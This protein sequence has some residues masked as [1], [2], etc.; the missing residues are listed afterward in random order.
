MTDTAPQIIIAPEF[1]T[2]RVETMDLP[3]LGQTMAQIIS[4]A[5]AQGKLDPKDLRKVQVYVDGVPLPAETGDQRRAAMRYVPEPGSIVNVVVNAQGG[6]GG[7]GDKAL[8]TVLQIALVVASFYVGGPAGPLAAS[9]AWV[10]AAAAVAVNVGGQMALSAIFAPDGDKLA[11]GQDKGALQ[12]A[13]NRYRPRAPMP[14]CLGL[15]RWGFDLA[16]PPYTTLIGQDQ[17]LNLAVAPHYGRCWVGNLKIGETLLADYPAADYSIEYFLEP[18]VPRR[19]YLYPNRVVQQNTQDELELGSAAEVYTSADNAERIELDVAFPN[20]LRWQKSSGKIV[21]QEVQGVIEYQAVGGGA[22]TPAPIGTF[23][24]KNGAAVPAGNWY[25]AGKT[26]DPIRRTFGFAV[27]KGQYNVRIRAFNPDGGEP[28][29]EVSD[30]TYLTAVRSIERQLP[31]IDENLAVIFLRIKSTDDLN[32]NLP[33][34]TGECEPIIPVYQGGNWNTEARSSNAAAL[35][36]W[37]LTGPAAA[38]PMPLGEFHSSLETT[39]DLIEANPSWKGALLVTEEKSQQ[40]VMVGLG[41]MGR[42]STFWNGSK[43]CFVPDWVRDAPRQV[44]TGRN[45]GGYRY[46]RTFPEPIHAVF[47]EFLNITEGSVDD[48]LYVYADG[49]DATNATLIESIRLDFA[50]EAERA[51]QEGRVYIAKRLLQVEMHE[52]QAGIDAV[53]TTYGDRVLVRHPATLYG[54]ADGR[55]MFRRWAGALVAGFRLDE[56]VEMEAGKTYGIDIRRPDGVIRGIPVVNVAGRTRDLAFAAPREAA[57][58]PRKGDMI[59]FGETDIITEDVEIIDVSPETDFSVTFRAIPYIG[60]QIADAINNPIPTIISRVTERVPPP[61]PRLTPPDFAIPSGLAIEATVSTWN[62]TPIAGFSG[63]WRARVVDAIE[64]ESFT[65]WQ[66]LR[67]VSGTNGILRTG[68]I[69]GAANPPDGGQEVSIDIEARTLLINGET[70]L[71]TVIEGIPVLAD[72]LAP[73]TFA[74][75]GVTR[76]SANGSSFGAIAVSATAQAAGDVQS[77]EVEAS[78][79]G[80]GAWVTP[81][82]GMLSARNPVGDLLGLKEGA[83]GYD[84]RARWL[85]AD[86]WPGPWQVVAGVVI[87]EGSSVSSDTKK[88]GGVNADEIAFN[89]VQVP[90]LVTTLADAQAAIATHQAALYTATT[91]VIDR[92][93][94]ARNTLYTASTG[95]VDR[96]NAILAQLNTP[97]TGVVAVL[98]SHASAI[99]DLQTGKAD[100]SVVTVLQSQ[101]NQAGTGIL[102][103]LATEEATSADLIANKANA[104]RV[105]LIEASVARLGADRVTEPTG[106]NWT[107]SAADN[108]APAVGASYVS[109]DPL[110]YFVTLLSSA[111]IAPQTLTKVE[112]GKLYRSTVQFEQVGAVDAARWSYWYFD[113]AGAYISASGLT[114]TQENYAVGS[115]EVLS[116]TFGLAGSG[117]TFILPATAI[118]VRPGFQMMRGSVVGASVRVRRLSAFVDVTAV[119]SAASKIA[120][121]E[122]TTANLQTGK[123]DASRVTLLEAQVQQAGTGLL[124]RTTAVETATSNLQ[125]GKADASRVTLLEAQVQQAGTGLLARMTA[126]ETATVNLQT[127]KADAS[128]VTSLEAKVDVRPNLIPNGSGR[129]GLLGWPSYWWTTNDWTWGRFFAFTR[130]ASGVVPNTYGMSE[131]LRVVP[132]YPYVLS[133]RGYVNGLT[134]GAVNLIVFAYDDNQGNGQVNLGQRALAPRLDPNDLTPLV[135]NI[136]AGKNFVRVSPAMINTFNTGPMDLAFWNL[137]LEQGTAP[138]VYS[139]EATA[140]T[141]GARTSTLEVATTNLQTGKA[142]ASRVTVVE[143][144]FGHIASNGRIV[145]AVGSNFTRASSGSEP[146]G[147]SFISLDGRGYF[148]TFLS[149]QVLLPRQLTEVRAGRVYKARAAGEQLTA[150]DTY[151]WIGYAFD[152]AGALIGAY[153]GA[154]PAMPVGAFTVEDTFGLAGSGAT[155]ILPAGT[156]AFRAG[157]QAMRSSG[158]GSIRIR[159]LTVVD[160]SDAATLGASVTSLQTA[161]ATMEGRLEGRALLQV[162]GGNQV[163]GMQLLA[164][165]GSDVSYSTIDFWA[166]AVRISNDGTNA[167]APFEVRGDVVRMKAALIDRLS[168]GTAISVG[169]FGFPVAL[170]AKLQPAK[171]GEVVSYGGDLG[172]VPNILWPTTGLDPLNAGESYLQYAE[173]HTSTGFIARR[174][175]QTPATPSAYNLTTTAAGP[176]TDTSGSTGPARIIT[177]G[178]NPVSVDNTYIITGQGVIA[179]KVNAFPTIGEPQEGTLIL[180]VWQRISGVWSSIGFLYCYASTDE[181][182][183]KFGTT[184][185]ETAGPASDSFTCSTTVEAWGLSLYSRSGGTS[186]YRSNTMSVQYTAQGTGAGI[187]TATAGNQRPNIEIRLKN[188]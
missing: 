107:L 19:S 77:L 141:L 99:G 39:Y 100:V 121:L 60:P 76:V 94:E 2:P 92:L 15:R 167:V 150:A 181:E 83:P 176:G 79:A 101:I 43:L 16:A 175:I 52:W 97:T 62:G 35:T 87:P 1:M 162:Q 147:S 46:R 104:S 5:I 128:R 120:T 64:G 6:G 89:A 133:G 113:A 78:P 163:S 33:V 164:V 91:G 155:I 69:A 72:L 109:S 4:A 37:L 95:L 56:E 143:A 139:E 18:G 13:A 66:A 75:E 51:F 61:R 50:C 173:G 115:H 80:A 26:K 112:A 105:A 73:T 36:R 41:K 180:R 93:T 168:V 165:S 172:Q 145:D 111:T 67:P 28:P 17:Y 136:P 158:A 116:P 38:K 29:D 12:D 85:Q 20:G 169:P 179:F 178:A 47:V 45:A 8:Q 31:I 157:L 142:D 40:D 86:N 184:I 146:V 74:A 182:W 24:N 68:R 70:S 188:V 82:G 153:G 171:D 58:S 108:P 119:E 42:F 185:E 122:T 21:P 130:P 96:T 84:L 154:V 9:A 25:V 34:I 63:R 65:P 44:F 54:L 118:Y 81:T 132:G 137:K 22:W 187:R 32:G 140:Q 156:V 27:P 149:S 127:G 114:T 71:A 159:E 123:A 7:G 3:A 48:E 170:E 138:T 160:T 90:G 23:Y 124:A 14:L 177:R 55:V 110:G 59:V 134:G 152:A 98:A 102:A 106:A 186:G 57:V 148:V 135:V 10:R 49:Y 125:T 174:K 117:A 144:T 183:D 53:A 166:S 131:Y 30:K 129:Q 103:R 151:R 11:T 161:Q 126:A 88:V